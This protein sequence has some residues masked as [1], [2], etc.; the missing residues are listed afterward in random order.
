MSVI[1]SFVP[2]WYADDF[3]PEA[4]KP[5]RERRLHAC[6]HCGHQMEFADQ[7]CAC[8]ARSNRTSWSR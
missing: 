6:E 1:R 4:P 5:E 2:R 8:T 3:K 7:E